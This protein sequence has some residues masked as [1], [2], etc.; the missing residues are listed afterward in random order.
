LLDISAGGCALLSRSPLAKSEII[1]ISFDI[2]SGTTV[3]VFG[4]IRNLKRDRSGTIMNIAFTKVSTKTLNDI[5]SLV[6]GFEDD[7][8]SNSRYNIS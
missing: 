1:M 7:L 5:R 4:K 8:N 2:S 3:S 6:F